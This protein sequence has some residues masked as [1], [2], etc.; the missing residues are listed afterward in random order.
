MNEKRTPKLCSKH[1]VELVQGYCPTCYPFPRVYCRGCGQPLTSR[2][3]R[4]RRMGARCWKKRE[5]VHMKELIPFVEFGGLEYQRMK[6]K[7]MGDVF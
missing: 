3:H 4:E 7:D 2:K 5:K 1:Q 6:Y